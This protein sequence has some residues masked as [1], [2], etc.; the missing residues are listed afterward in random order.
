[1][2]PSLYHTIRV[3]KKSNFIVEKVQFNIGRNPISY[4]NK[5]NFTIKTILFCI[6]RNQTSHLKKSN[7]SIIEY[8]KNMF[9]Q[10]P[11]KHHHSSQDKSLY[12]NISQPHLPKYVTLY[13]RPSSQNRGT[14]ESA[15]IIFF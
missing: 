9:V 10:S 5:S 1:M 8:I 4:W 2:N 15:N 14:L 11:D 7:G 3:R 6:G 12:N 13:H